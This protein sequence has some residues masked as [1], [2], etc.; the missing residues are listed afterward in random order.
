VQGVRSERLCG[1]RTAVLGGAD[2]VDGHAS[3]QGITA[4]PRSAAN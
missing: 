1:A 3:M 4:M 2:F